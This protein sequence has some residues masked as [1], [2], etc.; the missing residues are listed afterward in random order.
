MKPLETFRDQGFF[1]LK[2]LITISRGY[3]LITVQIH[4]DLF[5]HTYAYN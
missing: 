4:L 5:C 3:L 1:L 2:N